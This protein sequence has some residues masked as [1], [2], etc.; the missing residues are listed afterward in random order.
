LPTT[1][2]KAHIPSTKLHLHQASHFLTPS[3]EDLE[4]KKSYCSELEVGAMYYTYQSLLYLSFSISPTHPSDT[5]LILSYI[6]LV[7]CSCSTKERV[8][9]ETVAE[10]EAAVE[11][12]SRGRGGRGDM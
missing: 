3:D 8:N 6:L 4:D 7:M 1:F 11:E 5:Q 9:L 2:C 12:V 10:G